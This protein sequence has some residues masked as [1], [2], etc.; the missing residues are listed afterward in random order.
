M[1]PFRHEIPMRW[2]DLDSLNHVNNVVYLKYA[3]N[4][5]A[6]MGE[7]PEGPIGTM[8]VQFKRPI[9]LGRA[10]VVV[11]S[12]LEPQ[13]VSQTILVAG[14]EHEFATVETDFG[15]LTEDTKVNEQAHLASIALRHTDADASGRVSEPQVFELFQESRIPFISTVL[16]QMTPGRFVVASVEVRYHREIRWTAAQLEVRAWVSR[17][18]N[19]SFTIE[20]QLVEDGVVL[21]SSTAILVG[22]DA[23]TQASRRF[24]DQERESLA[25]ALA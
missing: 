9:L 14:S 18:G 8:R 17:V 6:A 12:R 2:A 16:T 15:T 25:A 19:A 22:F 21:T 11:E 3:E 10:P 1:T 20:A 5:R 7:L 24:S 23:D 13:R 4:A